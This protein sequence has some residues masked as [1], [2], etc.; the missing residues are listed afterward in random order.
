[1]ITNNKDAQ[2]VSDAKATM[3]VGGLYP[4]KDPKR[5]P[6]AMFEPHENQAQT[7]HR[8]S[9]AR[10]EQRGGLGWCEAAAI[11]A[12][13]KWHKMDKPDAKAFVMAH[14]ENWK[15]AQPLLDIS[16]RAVEG[17]GRKSLAEVE[18]EVRQHWGWGNLTRLGVCN[19]LVRGGFNQVTAIAK[20]DDICGPVQAPTNAPD[21]VGD[22]LPCPFC[23]CEVYSD[24]KYAEHP[25]SDCTL[26]TGL[27]LIE[28]WNTRLSTPA[29]S[30]QGEL[31]D[32]I[33][34]IKVAFWASL[35]NANAGFKYLDYDSMDEIASRAWEGFEPPATAALR[36]SSP[37]SDVV[38]AV[39]QAR[40]EQIERD[41]GIA[42][43]RAKASQ[44]AIDHLPDDNKSYLRGSLIASEQ[45]AQAVRDQAN[46]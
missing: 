33:A 31:A 16:S 36:T 1:M 19:M 29:P 37:N 35:M 42:D 26:S 2:V 8:Q 11:L 6:M 21:V 43:N 27:T 18:A 14:Y 44:T 45:I 20:S 12:D 17:D 46:G 24:G 38:A 9:L 22:L 5:F 34:A 15:A 3:R 39:A 4:D 25:E 7:N 40:R 28:Q 30:Q 41:A 23:G 13:R 10:L 32:S